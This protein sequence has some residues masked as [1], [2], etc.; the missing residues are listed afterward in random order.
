MAGS[1]DAMNELRHA[2]RSLRR[3]P[4]FSVTSIL[5]LALGIALVTAAS[6]LVDSVLIRPL[7]FAAADRVM[8]LAQED[9]Q[10]R[11]TGVSYPNFL[12]WQQQDSAGAFAQL[13]YVRGRGTTLLVNGERR[14][15]LG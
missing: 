7:P 14:P 8:V 12:D 15:V 1:C 9:A 5:T 6:S 2:L 3:A 10:G 4:V 13:A 11:A